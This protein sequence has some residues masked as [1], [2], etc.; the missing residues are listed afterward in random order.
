VKID[1]NEWIDYL[2]NNKQSLKKCQVLLFLHSVYYLII[3]G[4]EKI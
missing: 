1:L 4:T 3:A 2:E